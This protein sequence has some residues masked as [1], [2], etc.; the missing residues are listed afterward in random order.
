MEHI[1]DILKW[2]A[3]IGAAA[4]AL[5]LLKPLLDK[6]YSAKW[7]YG[8]WLVMAVMLLLAP[9]Q[10]EK[11]VPQ[12]PVAPAV[13]IEV[14][15]V[16][17]SVSR[18]EG[19]TIRPRAQTAP[20]QQKPAARNRTFPLEEL[21]LTLWATGGGMYLVYHVL[22][23]CWYTRRAKRW[24]RG[25]GEQTQMVYE[26]VRKDMGPKKLPPIRV[27][28]AVDSPMMTGLLRP[29][30]L[31][32]TE[33]F[34]ELELAFILR[35]EL[36][37]YRRCD[38]WYKLVLML[39]NTMHWFNPLI[40]LLRR[41]AERDLELTCD[42]A[43]V[44]GESVEVRRAYS[45]TLLASIHRQKG[46]GRA[47]LSTHFYGGK[48]VMKERFRNIL[49]KRGRK[50]GGLV[51]AVVLLAT[52]A[53]ACNFGLKQSDD[54]ALT[55]AELREWEEKLN[56]REMN[57]YLWRMYS[58]VDYLIPDEVLYSMFDEKDQ[59][60]ILGYPDVEAKVLSGTRNGDTITLEV[61]GNFRTHLPSGTLTL[62]NEEPVSFTTP[63][64][65]AVETQALEE[66]DAFAET[67]IAEAK[68][69]RGKDLEFTK[70]YI[71][72]LFCSE[73]MEISG[74]TYYIWELYYRML[75][76]DI[77]NVLFAGGMSDDHGWL[78][79]SQSIGSPVIIASVDKDGTVSIEEVTYSSTVGETGFTWEEYLYCHTH[80]GMNMFGLILDGWPEWG[81]PFL[82]SLRDGHET[83]ALDWQDV[84]HSYLDQ[85]YGIAADSELVEVRTFQA[86]ESLNSHDEARIVQTTCGD[87]TVMLFLDHVVYPVEVWNTT[88]TFW[89]VCGELWEPDA[90]E[91]QSWP[92]PENKP[93][94][95]PDAA[96]GNE[97]AEELTA[98][99]LATFT[100]YFN[101]R[102]HNGLLRVPYSGFGDIP[103]YYF[104]LM[105]Y[106]LGENI[107]DEAELAAVTELAGGELF[108]DCTKLT[109]D[110]ARNFLE[111]N[112]YGT[113]D[114]DID[115][116]FL[117][118]L[119]EMNYYL[120]EYD[121]IYMIHGDTM[122]TSYTFGRSEWC[123]DG[124]VK[125][126]YSTDLFYYDENE[127]L[128][129]RFDQPMC[130][131][132]APF[133]PDNFQAWL[134]VSNEMA[135]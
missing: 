120:E 15:K 51:L 118:P 74:K 122:M 47:V 31:L 6:R 84:A 116:V 87:R 50:W 82:T 61:E 7:R 33:D 103:N 71:S 111:T 4:L 127:H 65:T 83:W 113:S 102:Q 124:T 128:D 52:L 93:E 62:V 53:A 17:V 60:N 24:S 39:A 133:N 91:V 68:E 30:L 70:K 95:A 54:G 96:G 34:G 76:N 85:V 86:D 21:L 18:Q 115:A 134:M 58:H 114:I 36:T 25:P 35:H 59:S 67:R 20:A 42:D 110:D 29:T 77:D 1:L 38:L 106:D 99:E 109:M 121:A 63:L 75:P 55:D 5:T 22:G 117:E 16:E 41:E 123:E 23:T 80:L 78:T 11:A 13:V 26:A 40:Y 27:T 14:P 43:V 37:H 104:S 9:V 57:P 94:P 90:P 92:V 135:E 105:L 28:S 108:T 12:P 72:N 56:T 49:G 132:L 48:R 98:D 32:P 45:E 81:T 69:Y 107:S 89:E 112:F 88:L 119:K 3:V 73:S 19:V 101:V 126:Y 64:Y 2:S 125:L 97:Q 130:A 8:A 79:E 131:T 100:S 44:A 10:W 129:V 46:L 66:M